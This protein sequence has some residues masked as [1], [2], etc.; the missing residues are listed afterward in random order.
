[1]VA[2]KVVIPA[3]DIS[4]LEEKKVYSRHCMAQ[5][6]KILINLMNGIKASWL[7]FSLSIL[8]VLNAMAFT[9]IKC[10]Q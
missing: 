1:L 3:T 6:W 7:K 4:A 10:V 9:R 5:K 2:E 8:N